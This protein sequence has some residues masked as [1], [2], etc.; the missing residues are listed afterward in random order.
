MWGFR[1]SFSSNDFTLLHAFLLNKNSAYGRGFGRMSEY[2]LA[3]LSTL[4]IP[5]R[6]VKD[7]FTLKRVSRLIGS[8]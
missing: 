1:E 8:N 6:K 2:R 7:A 5:H 3:E 4:T